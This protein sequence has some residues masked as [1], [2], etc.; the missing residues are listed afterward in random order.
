MNEVTDY[1][2]TETFKQFSSTLEAAGKS[3]EL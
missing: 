1:K 2:E 3:T